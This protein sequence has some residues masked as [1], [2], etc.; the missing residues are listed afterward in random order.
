MRAWPLSI[1]L[2]ASACTG[3]ATQTAAV[4][5]LAPAGAWRTDLGPTAPI[6]RDWWRAFGDPELIRLV[7]RALANNTDLGIAAARVRDARAQELAA[8]AQL[9]PT[10]DLS[11]GFA[12]SRSVNAFGR[13]SVQTALQPQFVASYEVDLFG[14]LEDQV[15]A[16]RSGVSASQAARDA[17]ALGVASATASGYV[18]LLA[19]D[20]RLQITRE[21]LTARDEAMRIARSRAREG[22]SPILE[23]RQAEAEYEA[24]A[25]LIPQLQLA[26]ARQEDALS[27]LTGDTAHRIARGVAFN[28]LREPAIPEGLPSDLL[29]RRPDVAQ[30]EYQLAATDASLSAARKRFLPQLRLSG[31]AGAA[32]STLLADPIAIWSLGGSVLAPLFEGDRLRAQ[33]ESAAAQRDVA[34]FTYRRTALT[35]FREVEDNLAAVQ[36]LSQQLDHLQAQRAALAEGLRLATNRYRAGYSTYLEQLDAQRGLLSAELSLIQTRADELAAR[37][38]LY[39]AMGGGWQAPG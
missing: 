13:P 28:V 21:T 16:A 12:H 19:L 30:A 8:R 6:E 32:I 2:L 5:P 10:L 36:R 11:G 27:L 7:E 39:Q 38:A 23:Q 24:T 25:Q 33:A 18:T 3:P 15:A 22:Y 29:R 34:A 17:A 37:I 9:L 1:A 35:A 4:P 31:S 26:I 14:R 20:A